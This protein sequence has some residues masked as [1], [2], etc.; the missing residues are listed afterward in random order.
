MCIRDSF[1]RIQEILDTEGVKYD[2]K[3]LVELI[4]KHFPDWRRV[5]NECQRYSVGGSIDTG[6]LA[7]FSD[8]KTDDLFKSLKEKNFSEV[9]KWVVHNL[10]NDPSLL[11]R[12]IYD[13]CYGSLDGPGVAAAVLIIAKYQ[14]Q[15][16]FVADQEINLLACLTEIMV[17]C[18][19][20]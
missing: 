16:G 12:R 5:L 13:G 14:Y 11:L 10:D 17:E 2:N 15:I 20:K 18:E 6:I 1:K 7:T 8:V 4:Q 3:V 19:F 9:R